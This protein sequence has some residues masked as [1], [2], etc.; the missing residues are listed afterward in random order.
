M[1]ET[2]YTVI[3]KT[4][5]FEFHDARLTL[6]NKD[7]NNI[8][9]IAKG[10]CIHKDAEENPKGYDLEIEKAHITFYGISDQTYEPGRPWGKDANG[11]DIPL[12]PEIIYEGEKAWD[13][14]IAESRNSFHVYSEACKVH[15]TED[16]QNG[17]DYEICGVGIE[18]VFFIK[19]RAQSVKVEWDEYSK[20][21]WYELRK[22]V[23]SD[24]ILSTPGGEQICKSCISRTYDKDELF[25]VEDPK[26]VDP[27]EV[28]VWLKYS[29]KEYWGN[30]TDY[31]GIDAY[32]DLQQQLPKEITLKCCLSCKHGSMCPLGNQPNELFCLKDLKVGSKEELSDLSFWASEEEKHKRSRRY[33]DMC[34][35]WETQIDDYFTYTDF[36]CYLR[37]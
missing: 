24:L 18:P 29:D 3:N 27:K 17:D 19:F 2:K 13:R 16:S 7:G 36:P 10:L 5:I 20:P 21:A 6:E 35:D 30:G 22:A 4:D 31:T 26:D 32:A 1:N 23:Y 12:G 28:Q 25:S 9:I 15:H 14:I 37:S 34:E 8:T 33:T 11:N